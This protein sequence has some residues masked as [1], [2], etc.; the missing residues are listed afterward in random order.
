MAI[1]DEAMSVRDETISSM[2]E[3]ISMLKVGYSH[4]VLVCLA[5]NSLEETFYVFDLY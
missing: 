5:Q 2:Q 4:Y 3:E 1:R